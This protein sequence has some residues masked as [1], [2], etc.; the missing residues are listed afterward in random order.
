MYIEIHALRN[1]VR[2]EG[3]AGARSDEVY[4]TNSLPSSTPNLR[5][6]ACRCTAAVALGMHESASMQP[7]WPTSMLVLRE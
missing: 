7:L 2:G 5:F 6:I 3:R 4:K 1:E